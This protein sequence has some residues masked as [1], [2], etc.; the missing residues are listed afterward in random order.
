MGRYSTNPSYA[1][2][3]TR[4]GVDDFTL[5]W[6][7]DRYRQGS[8]LRF[9]MLSS[10]LTDKRGAERFAKKWKL[11]IPAL[12]CRQHPQ[13]LAKR[14]PRS[15]CIRCETM[16]MEANL[17]AMYDDAVKQISTMHSLEFPT[18]PHSRPNPTVKP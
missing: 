8:R 11:E 2:R 17:K 10:R 18:V 12:T 9:P 15:E 3:I 1:H 5:F 13:Y 16:W 6:T 4:I 14:A 7:C